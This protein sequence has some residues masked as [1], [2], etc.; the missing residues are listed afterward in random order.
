MADDE[1]LTRF[2]AR[3]SLHV[4]DGW[5]VHSLAEQPPYAIVTK[6]IAPSPQ[7]MNPDGARHICR[8]IKVTGRRIFVRPTACPVDLN[9]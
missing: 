6:T 3:I 2:R 5:H 4:R 9:S 8:S 1:V 7:G